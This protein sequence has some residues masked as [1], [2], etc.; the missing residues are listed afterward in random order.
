MCDYCLKCGKEDSDGGA[1]RLIDEWILCCKC[2][3]WLH[4]TCIRISMK[5]YQK[6]QYTC[7]ICEHYLENED[8]KED[9][10]KNNNV[11]TNDVE[12][13]DD[14]CDDTK[15]VDIHEEDESIE[16]ECIWDESIEDESIEN[17]SIEGESIED[18]EGHY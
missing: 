9:N 5:E 1:G 4:A 11:E 17:E 7:F 14:E 13:G 8:E 10:N 12:S 2:E 3:R 16:D 18:E 6:T 15:V